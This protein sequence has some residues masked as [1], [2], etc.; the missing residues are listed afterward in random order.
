MEVIH[1][2]KVDVNRFYIKRWNG[3]RGLDELE[4]T[5]NAIIVD[6]CEYV[7]QG[8][9]RLTSSLQEYDA[10]KTKYSLQKEAN[11]LEQKCKTQ[12]S[13]TQNI[14]YQIQHWKREDRRTQEEIDAWS[15]LL[16]PWKTISW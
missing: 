14:E 4:S 8:R 7:K 2:P 11:L 1:H 15:M 13:A 12:D 16:G 10:G 6:L 9:D 3:K 5:Y